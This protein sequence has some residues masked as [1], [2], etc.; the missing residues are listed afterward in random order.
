[1]GSNKRRVTETCERSLAADWPRS[2]EE[3]LKNHERFV[4]WFVTLRIATVLQEPVDIFRRVAALDCRCET[5]RRG[6]SRAGRTHV[7]V[8]R[9]AEPVSAR[10]P[11]AEQAP[12]DDQLADV[13]SRVIGGQHQ[14]AQVRLSL[15]VWNLGEQID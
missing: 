11:R 6:S 15:T 10:F 7:R 3:P 5:A 12:D 1:M 2:R 14:L 8:D 9:H 4:S 13:I